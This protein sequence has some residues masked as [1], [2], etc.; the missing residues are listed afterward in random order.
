MAI[1]GLDPT[2]NGRRRW[3]PALDDFEITFDGR[4]SAG[5]TE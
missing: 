1:V 2:I 3:K 4:L 5:K